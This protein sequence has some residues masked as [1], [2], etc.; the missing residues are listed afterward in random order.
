MVVFN[1][2]RI[3]P[4][5]RSRKPLPLFLIALFFLG[6]AIPAAGSSL[7]YKNYVVRYDRGW[8]ILCEPYVVQKGDWILKIFRQKGEIAYNDFREFLGIFQ[9]LNPHVQ[10]ID[11]LRPGQTIEIPLR[12]LEQGELPGQA[13]GMVTIPFVSLTRVIDVLHQN[14]PT[15]KIQSGDTVSKLITARFGRYGSEAYKEGVKLLQAANPQITDINRIYA[16]QTIFMP[17]TAIREQQWYHALYDDKGELRETVSRDALA[18]GQAG[19]VPDPLPAAGEDTGDQEPVDALAAAADAVG[20]TL[21]NKGTYFAPIAG[22]EDFEIDLSRHPILEMQSGSLLF[23]RDGNIMNQAPEGVQPHLPQVKIVPYD[24]RAT[25]AQLVG[26]IFEALNGARDPGDAET[27]GF[28]DQGITLT[29]RSKWSRPD[30]DQ[31]RLCIAPINDPSERTPAS[32]HRY[33]EQHGIVLRELL[34]SGRIV[35]GESGRAPGRHAVKDILVLPQSGPKDFVQRISRIL[36]FSYTAG[37]TVTFP[38]AGLEIQAYADLVATADGNEILVD[39]G[40][41]HGDTLSA[42]RESGQNIVQIAPGDT[43][44]K[45]LRTILDGLTVPYTENPSFLAAARPPQFNTTVTVQGLLLAGSQNKR[46]LL[47]AADLPAAVSDLLSA[48]G[49]SMVKW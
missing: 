33:L 31:R 40:D 16:D 44:T 21:R 23:T 43:P 47:T 35:S 46:T 7:I 5:P 28:E 24:E 22:E 10:D 18:G 37:V 2:L 17:E 13:A 41:L 1:M 3:S 9:R 25:A 42:L 4:S 26:T 27:I 34:P 6:W 49:I 38:Y 15:Y 14:L 36:S 29:V 39:F 20:G 32:M 19:T 12:K 45:A 8:D 11:L 48:G 30:T